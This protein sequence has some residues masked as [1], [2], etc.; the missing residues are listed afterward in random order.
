MRHAFAALA[1]SVLMVG[2]AHADVEVT[3]VSETGEPLADAVVTLHYA[4][5]VAAAGFAWPLRMSQQDLQFDP[6][7]LVAPVGAEVAFPNLDRVRHHVYSFSR[8]NRL[9]V[10]V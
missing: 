5:P 6:F 7:V 1:M 8:G 4:G 2:A 3:V 9:L 10:I